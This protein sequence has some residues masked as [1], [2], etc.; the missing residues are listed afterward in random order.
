MFLCRIN[1]DNRISNDSMNSTQI[2][3]KLSGLFFSGV[4]LCSSILL[5]R[6]S[7]VTTY[8]IES[9]EHEKSEYPLITHFFHAP[10]KRIFFMFNFICIAMAKTYFHSIP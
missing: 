9:I 10:V 5:A 8:L 4:L 6:Q 3:N 2:V 7:D 1:K